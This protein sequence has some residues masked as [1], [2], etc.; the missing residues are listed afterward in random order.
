MQSS[1]F[2][3]AYI[4][5]MYGSKSSSMIKELIAYADITGLRPLIINHSSDIRDVKNGISSHSS[6]YK[7]LPETVSVKIAEKLSDIDIAEYSVIGIDEAQ[8]FPDLFE[9]VLQWLDSGIYVVI[10]G[11]NG[12]AKKELFG[13]IYKLLP[14]MDKLTFCNAICK[15]CVSEFTGSIITPEI[16][17][18]MKASF[19]KKI[20]GDK[21]LEIDVG[22][23]DK[24]IPSC[25]R[26]FL[27]STNIGN[28]EVAKSPK[29]GNFIKS[30]RET[31][32]SLGSGFLLGVICATASTILTLLIGYFSGI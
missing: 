10:A 21:N 30:Q 23:T 4:G 26:H 16:L 25:R 9:I 13:D 1:G 24:Y 5:C 29:P 6:M 17:G 7:G 8:F 3:S 18:T 11:L 28:C 27:D 22:A 31:S 14:H 15:I 20:N 19:S 2:L 12:N 32:I